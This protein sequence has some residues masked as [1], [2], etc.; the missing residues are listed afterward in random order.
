MSWPEL[1]RLRFMV[2]FFFFFFMS[3]YSACIYAIV[4][5]SLQCISYHPWLTQIALKRIV[6]PQGWAYYC[7]G[8]KN[9]PKG[10]DDAPVTSSVIIQMN[11]HPPRTTTIYKL[12]INVHF[13][14]VYLF[15]GGPLCFRM[16]FNLCE[17]IIILNRF[18]TRL[19]SVTETGTLQ[20]NT[21]RFNFFFFNLDENSKNR[22]R[23]RFGK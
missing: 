1:L 20:I 11:H 9:L 4:S 21:T 14:L 7:R 13:D 23:L 18:Y 16:Y 8:G 12:N 17:I 15:N 2:Q 19:I 3:P 6:A 5:D 10:D 22:M